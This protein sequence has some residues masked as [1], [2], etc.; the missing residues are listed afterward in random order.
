MIRIGVSACLIGAPVRYDGRAATLEDKLLDTWKAEGRLMAVCPEVLGGLPTPRPSAER[1][2]NRVVT[3][4]G[5]DQTDAFVAGAER[6]VRALR[7]AGIKAVILKSKSPSCGLGRIYDGS[8]EGRLTDG[9]GLFALAAKAE[10]LA[11]FRD[12]QIQAASQWLTDFNQS[13]EE[14]G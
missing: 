7:S 5:E 1:L 14:I 9:D 3:Q 6:A 11:V 2:G 10:G 13:M 4:S 12:D 8:F